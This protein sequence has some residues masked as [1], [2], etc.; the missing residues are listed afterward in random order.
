MTRPTVYQKPTCTTCRNLAFFLR[1]R[2]IDYDAVDYFIDPIPRPKLVELLGKMGMPARELL[3]PKESRALGLDP[4]SMTDDEA[5]D[6][7]TSHP[8]LIQRPIVEIGDRA[9]LARPVE[10]IE[11]ILPRT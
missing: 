4:A 3:R 6:A 11:E 10:R 9:V 1:D 2:G 7:M 8:E 5:L